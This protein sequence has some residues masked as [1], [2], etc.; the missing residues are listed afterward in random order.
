MGMKNKRTIGI[1]IY[2]ILVCIGGLIMV[3]PLIRMV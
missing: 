3:Y 2:H 1:T